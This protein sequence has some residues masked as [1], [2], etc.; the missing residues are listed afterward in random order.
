MQAKIFGVGVL[1][2]LQVLYAVKIGI[3]HYIIK[4]SKDSKKVVKAKKDKVFYEWTFAIVMLVKF[5]IETNII[6]VMW[7]PLWIA[8]MLIANFCV[9]MIVVKYWIKPRQNTWWK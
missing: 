4:K 6:E 8:D 2:F 5:M 3:R 9:A 7:I 1:T